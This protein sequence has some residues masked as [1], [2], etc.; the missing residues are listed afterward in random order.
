MT[1]VMFVYMFVDELAI[2]DLV[3]STRHEPSEQHFISQAGW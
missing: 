2:L 3:P 1:P